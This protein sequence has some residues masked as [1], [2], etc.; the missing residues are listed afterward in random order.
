MHLLHWLLVP[1]DPDFG[2]AE[3]CVAISFCQAKPIFSAKYLSSG[4]WE[5]DLHLSEIARF[6]SDW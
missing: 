4:F 5:Q 6:K 1:L 2:F 3:Q